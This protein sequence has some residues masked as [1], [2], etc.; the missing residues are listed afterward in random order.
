MSSSSSYRE[1]HLGANH[2]H[3]EGRPTFPCTFFCVLANMASTSLTLLWE[4]CRGSGA[5]DSRHWLS[6][7]GGRSPG[8]EKRVPRVLKRVRSSHMHLY[9]HRW[10]ACREMGRVRTCSLVP[11]T[12]LGRHPTSPECQAFGTLAGVGVA[13]VHTLTRGVA[14]AGKTS[15]GRFS[16]L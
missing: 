15:R 7:G 2:A 10:P 13:S 1:H 14:A 6:R 16:V 12:A 5:E 3:N 8:V 4:H 11:S 9:S